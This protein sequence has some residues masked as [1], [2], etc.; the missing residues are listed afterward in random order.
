MELIGQ[1]LTR[2]DLEVQLGLTSKEATAAIR[3]MVREGA[4]YDPDGSC[5]TNC[6]RKARTALC[7]RGADS[8]PVCG[9]L[10]P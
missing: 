6:E 1:K 9:E 4:S 2:K 7:V 10:R 8:R 5:R 3:K